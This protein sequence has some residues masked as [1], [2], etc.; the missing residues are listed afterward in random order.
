MK[1]YIVGP[2][3]NGDGVYGLV[4]EKGE[5]LASHLCSHLGFARSDLE[6]RRPERQKE[7]K[8][9]F[10]DYKVLVLGEDEMTR[11]R[12]IALNKEF[13]KDDKHNNED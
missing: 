4:S 6:S 3:N 7:W 8:E 12:I 10:G 13:H 1:L 2:E 5:G 11:E 9:R